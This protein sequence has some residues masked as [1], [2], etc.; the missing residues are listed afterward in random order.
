MPD[1]VQIFVWQHQQ[2]C[3]QGCSGFQW[4][5][6]QDSSLST[7]FLSTCL[8]SWTKSSFWWDSRIMDNCQI[9]K[10]WG[11]AWNFVTLLVLQQQWT[12]IEFCHSVHAYQ[13]LRTY[14]IWQILCL[15]DGFPIKTHWNSTSSIQRMR[16]CG[17]VC[18]CLLYQPIQTRL[19]TTQA[20]EN[21]LV[22]KSAKRMK[23]PVQKPECSKSDSQILGF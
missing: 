22:T 10:K 15:H 21:E 20:L 13:R 5:L 11:K 14:R 9:V 12:W 8:P 23:G 6:H 3:I 2:E 1:V 17:E 7:S 18:N 4:M 16:Y 19:I